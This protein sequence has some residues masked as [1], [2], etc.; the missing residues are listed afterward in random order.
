M[1][2]ISYA[3]TQ[4]VLRTTYA[5]DDTLCDQFF[6]LYS[7]FV[8]CSLT[9][10]NCFVRRWGPSPGSPVTRV[11]FEKLASNQ[12]GYT[13]VQASDDRPGGYML[14]YLNNFRGDRQPRVIETWR[15][16][17]ARLH[18]LTGLEPHPA[19]YNRAFP[20][21]TLG[22]EF[23]SMLA[24]G[25]KLSDDWSPIWNAVFS[26]DGE[27]YAIT[28]ECAGQWVFGGY[29]DCNVIIKV[30]VNRISTVRS[31]MPICEFARRS[32]ESD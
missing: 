18:D 31:K 13:E 15:V 14:L 19:P 27:D 22:A 2:A 24:S 28:R 10:D 17:T 25:E 8:S 4:N 32:A 26:I 21:E 29:Y 12:Y 6:E 9:N 23:S 11:L 16:P 3:E 30:T 7:S 20:K 5:L 1:A